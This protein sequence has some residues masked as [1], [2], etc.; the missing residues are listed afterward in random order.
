[1]RF[2]QIVVTVPDGVRVSFGKLAAN[3]LDK[4]RDEVV[5][6]GAP[7]LHIDAEVA[8][9]QIVLRS[10]KRPKRLVRRLR[11]IARRSR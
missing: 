9:G 7:E 10:P 2:G 11:R 3:V 8:H 1:M 6:P 4:T 5:L